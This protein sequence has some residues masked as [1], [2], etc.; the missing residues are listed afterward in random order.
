MRIGMFCDMY[1]PHVSGVTNHIKL[2]KRYYESQGHEVYL[3]TFGNTSYQD[4]EPNVIR[5]L[6]LPWG[7]T[8][9]S[10]SLLFGHDAR[11]LIPTL[12]VIH[13]HHP[14]QSG[15]LVKP[16]CERY[17]IPLVFTNHTRYDLYSDT[18]AS[19]VPQGA[20]YLYL[21]FALKEMLDSCALVITPSKSIAEWLD[22]FVEYKRG[23]VI[24][25]GIDIE[26]FAHPQRTTT[27]AS[28]GVKDDEFLL[29]YAGR[30]APE[31]ST[32]YLL[33]EFAQAAKQVPHLKL[34]M[35][36]GGADLEKA[37]AFVY[38]HNL[39]D[40]V[41]FTGMQ[42]YGMLPTFESLGDAFVTGS[43]S[44][45]HPLVVLE[46]M[47]AGMCV[48]GVASPGISDTVDHG[49]HG[50]LAESQ[51]EGALARHMVE[52]ATKPALTHQ[53][54]ANARAHVEQYSLANTAGV[55]L[56]HYERLIAPRG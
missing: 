42:P 38:D 31:K 10:F 9:W 1:M 32:D 29:C 52:L 8:G 14:F 49:V 19:L 26:A 55:T 48:L 15:A 28:V 39:A 30:I 56:A 46:A 2:Y 53:L 20:R 21:K 43:V 47:A 54:R 25:N 44:E 24:P 4:D 7:N 12:D 40:R 17:G 11:A 23:A 34:L 3:F 36:G 27:R 33:S 45:V 22:E 51:A 6:A 16:Y 41:I 50:L 13:T 37:R 35:I 5:S 18:Y